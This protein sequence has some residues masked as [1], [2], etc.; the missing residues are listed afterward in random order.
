MKKTNFRKNSRGAEAPLAP[1]LR[2]PDLTGHAM[3]IIRFKK[4]KI[5]LLTNEQQQSYQNTKNWKDKYGEDKNFVKLGTIVIIQ[6]NT[7]V[8]GIAHLKYLTAIL[9]AFLDL[10]YS[11]PNEIPIVF[12]TMDATIII[13]NNVNKKYR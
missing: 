11:A 8:L 4:K 3:Q 1:W 5:K 2:R 10:K 7:E 12:H 6:R 13:T 9:T